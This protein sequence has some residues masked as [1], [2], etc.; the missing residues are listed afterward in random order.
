M[1]ISDATLNSYTN[2]IFSISAH[3]FFLSYI[4]LSLWFYKERLFG[5][6]SNF[7]Y[8]L[9]QFER[10]YFPQGGYG[11]AGVG[12]IEILPLLA[13]KFGA[14][15]DTI[16]KLN[17]MS[18]PL[19]FYATFL[20]LF[21]YL[22]EP[23]AAV[24]PMILAACVGAPSPFFLSVEF[25][26]SLAFTVVAFVLIRHIADGGLLEN[27]TKV[28]F[29]IVVMIETFFLYPAGFLYLFYVVILAAFSHGKLRSIHGIAAVSCVLFAV[30][31]VTNASEYEQGRFVIE[32]NILKSDYLLKM[33]GFLVSRYW[34]VLAMCALAVISYLR[35]KRYYAATYSGGAFLAFFFLLN[36]NNNLERHS[37]DYIA[38]AYQGMLLLGSLPLFGDTLRFSSKSIRV[39]T[40]AFT[41]G[42]L[43][44]SAVHIFQESDIFQRRQ[45][46]IMRILSSPEAEGKVRL[47]LDEKNI[48]RDLIAFNWAFTYESLLLSTMSPAIPTK[49]LMFEKNFPRFKLKVPPNPRFIDMPES[50][51]HRLNTMCDPSVLTD[52][53][54]GRIHLDLALRADQHASS[55]IWPVIE[56]V[57]GNEQPLR[58]DQTGEHR[59]YFRYIW[60]KDKVVVDKIGIQ[61]PLEIDVSRRYAQPIKV[62]IPD[63]PGEY[64]LRYD[65]VLHGRGW[66]GA[67]QPRTVHV[68]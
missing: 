67:G 46:M 11:R 10:F 63:E 14:T 51:Y 55:T 60:I 8:L 68:R 23:L 39:A 38:H 58:S 61:T 30:W 64:T 33:A 15:I 50:E 18:I 5:D 7:V 43:A 2:R 20:M 53:F 6:T 26:L 65:L 57:N 48:D 4:F 49:T 62:R 52:E 16:V 42:V 37:P 22:K 41:A 34:S 44:L 27:K 19:L 59:L 35:Q 13:V 9:S 31:K 47:M 66:L 56:I 45:S 25:S 40:Y 24:P 32:A 3:A 21:Y 1:A 29:L 36:L 12:L 54:I 17:S 28:A